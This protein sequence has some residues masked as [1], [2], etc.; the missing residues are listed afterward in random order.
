MNEIKECL[1]I[2]ENKYGKLDYLINNAGGQFMSPAE[3]MT[4]KGWKTVI[5][6][7]LNGSFLVTFQCFHK[8][9]KKQNYGNIIMVTANNFH[10]MPN[11]IASGAARAGS[12]FF[13]FFGFFLAFK[14]MCTSLLFLF[15]QKNCNNKPNFLYKNQGKKKFAIGVDNITKTLAIE[16]GKYNIRV[17]C[18]APGFIDSSGLRKYPKHVQSALDLHDGMFL[19][20]C[21]DFY[22]AK[23]NLVF[24]FLFFF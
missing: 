1:N 18:V 22:F 11:M 14:L 7:N 3:N 19:Y 23:K 9:F 16:W 15:L 13:Y 24:V 20:L 17:N 6:L 8:F 10:G 5:D 12:H 4:E 21:C 2:I